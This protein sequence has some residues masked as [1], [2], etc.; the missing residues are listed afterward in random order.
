MVP[1]HKLCLITKS[2]YPSIVFSY[3][4]KKKTVLQTDTDFPTNPRPMGGETSQ[5]ANFPTASRPMRGETSQTA[6]LP[7]TPQPAG[8]MQYKERQGLGNSVRVGRSGLRCRR[9][10]HLVWSAWQ[11]SGSRCRRSTRL[12]WSAW[13]CSGRLSSR[14]PGVR[15]FSSV[16][17][18]WSGIVAASSSPAEPDRRRPHE[19]DRSK[20]RLWSLAHL[21]SSWRPSIKTIGVHFCVCVCVSVC[22]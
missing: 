2:I 20:R 21:S 1:Q 22:K 9:S 11:R 8:E 6:I 3:L 5:T 16:P 18:A 15:R 19:V 10:T 17:G 13:Q 14:P 7:T 4:Q 12:V